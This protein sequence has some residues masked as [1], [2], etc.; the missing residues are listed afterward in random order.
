M[1]SQSYRVLC[2][3]LAQILNFSISADRDVWLRQL[4][5]AARS[6]TGASYVVLGETDPKEGFVRTVLRGERLQREV[7]GRLQGVARKVTSR[8]ESLFENEMGRQTS[9]RQTTDGVPGRK[10]VGYAVVPVQRCRAGMGWLLVGRLEGDPPLDEASSDL[11]EC[12]SGAMA[13][14]LDN[15]SEW[16]R[17][18]DL[19]MTDA[20]TSIPNYRYLQKNLAT[21]LERAR[22][23]GEVFTIVMVDVDNLKQYNAAHGHLAG[24]EV[25]RQLAALLRHE[26]RAT[27]TVAKY[28]G[29]EFLLILPRTEAMGGLALSERIRKRICDT[30]EGRGHET[31]SAS[32]GVASFP[33]DGCDCE[34]LIASADRVLYE[35]KDEGRNRVVWTRNAQEASEAAG[36]VDPKEGARRRRSEDA[37]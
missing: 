1:E 33:I 4:M 3:D 10:T 30:L 7:V 16:Q 15:A 6:Y 31:L 2:K 34:S 26:L 13:S 19:A 8:G 27:D 18:E 36:A 14:G 12:L 37:A 35:A 5:E 23:Y 20:L 22:R 24:S 11:L 9:F 28:G 21:E 29:D 25:L 32:F 17:L